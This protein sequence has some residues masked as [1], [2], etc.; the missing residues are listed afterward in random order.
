MR[1]RTS[2][3]SFDARWSC[4]SRPTTARSASADTTAPIP[5]LRGGPRGFAGA[6]RADEHH[7]ARVGEPEHG[8]VSSASGDVH[9]LRTLS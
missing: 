4:S 5:E 9:D 3:A 1:S 2:K 6:G 8:A 7:E